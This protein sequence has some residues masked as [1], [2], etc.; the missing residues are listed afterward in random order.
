MNYD[1][2]FRRI[3]D[4]A[5]P[6]CIYFLGGSVGLA[7]FLHADVALAGLSAAAFGGLIGARSFENATQIKATASTTSATVIT[8][9]ATA[10]QTQGVQNPAPVTDSSP[11]HKTG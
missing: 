3:A 4:M 8:P 1:D 2:I 10:T 11:P 5:R 7:P 9:T 6:A